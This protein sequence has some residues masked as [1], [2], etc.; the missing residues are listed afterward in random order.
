MKT[1]TVLLV[2]GTALAVGLGLYFAQKNKS[3][4]K[5]VADDVKTEG[6]GLIEAVIPKVK[7]GDVDFTPQPAVV[8]QPSLSI[9]QA[10]QTGGVR[11][12]PSPAV[13]IPAGVGLLEVVSVD[14]SL[15][16]PLTQNELTWLQPATSTTTT[17][18]PRT[19]TGFEL[20]M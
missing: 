7:N 14:P 5:E 11:T 6:E 2:G 12:S 18:A 3:K 16:V 20:I 10:V 9:E 17:R 13:E 15:N 4:I 8:Q 1:K 19:S